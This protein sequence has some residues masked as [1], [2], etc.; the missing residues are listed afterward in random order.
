MLGFRALQ[1]RRFPARDARAGSRA[2]LAATITASRAE[3]RHAA[4]SRL[5]RS[6]RRGCCLEFGTGNPPASA[7]MVLSACSSRHEAPRIGCEREGQEGAP[8]A[9]L[10][11]PREKVR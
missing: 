2:G 6:R 5:K 1:G 10:P 9:H 7:E 8:E 4:R 11:G 3:P